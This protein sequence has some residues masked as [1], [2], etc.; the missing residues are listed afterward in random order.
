MKRALLLGG[1]ALLAAG[2]Y[3]HEVVVAPEWEVVAQDEKGRPVADVEVMQSWYYYPFR[4]G[5]HDEA[6]TDANGVARFPQRTLQ[7]PWLE[8][9]AGS[10]MKLLPHGSTGPSASVYVSKPGYGTLAKANFDLGS[11]PRTPEDV[12]APAKQRSVWTLYA[13]GELSPQECS[14]TL[15]PR[16]KEAYR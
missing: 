10:V 8:M 9:A 14:T 2:L 5:R 11:W 3:P 1:L 4:D 6:R 13:C 12:A 15:F 16:Y 7:V